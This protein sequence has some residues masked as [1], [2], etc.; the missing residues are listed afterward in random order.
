MKTYIITASLIL[1]FVLFIATDASYQ[2]K[3][4]KEKQAYILEKQE[5]LKRELIKQ[6][7]YKC[8]IKNPC[9]YCLEHLD[10]E[11]VCDCLD[12][13]VNGKPPCGECIGEILEGEGNPLVK[14]YFAKSITKE[15]GE[16]HSETMK[17][18]IKEK[19]SN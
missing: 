4:T 1:L 6:G 10:E 9:T 13:I 17:N 15:V 14:E 11:V 5:Q 19:Y 7:R 2:L 16:Q 8:C 12:D 3:T 18:I